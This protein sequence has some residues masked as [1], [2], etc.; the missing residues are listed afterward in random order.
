[1]VP[2]FHIFG[3]EE[4]SALGTA[5]SERVPEPYVGM[6]EGDSNAL[7]KKEGDEVAL[8][9]GNVIRSLPVRIIPS[10]PSGL[11]ALPAGLPGLEGIVLPKWGKVSDSSSTEREATESFVPRS[12]PNNGKSND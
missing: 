7:G 6:N 9:L 8:D 10:L 4:L 11:I 3:S 5:V 12:G 1:M 2:A